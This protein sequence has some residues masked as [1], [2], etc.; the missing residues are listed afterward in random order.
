MTPSRSLTRSPLWENGDPNGGGR[1]RWKKYAE[2]F[3]ICQL[4]NDTHMIPWEQLE[5]YR[6]FYNRLTTDNYTVSLFGLPRFT[7]KG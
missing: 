4:C 5:K 1:P 2:A 6:Y 3:D 7:P